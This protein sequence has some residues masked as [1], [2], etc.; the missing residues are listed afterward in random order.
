MASDFS[1]SASSNYASPVSESF[2]RV[3]SPM[4]VREA[5]K[6]AQIEYPNIT[7]QLT[8]GPG[9]VATLLLVFLAGGY[10]FKTLQLGGSETS[11]QETV[12]KNEKASTAVLLSA[13]CFMLII[14]YLGAL[15]PLRGGK[16]YD[17]KQHDAAKS[18]TEASIT[19]AKKMFQL[20]D[21]ISLAGSACLR[22]FADVMVLRDL[23]QNR[24]W[25]AFTVKLFMLGLM[26]TVAAMYTHRQT[27]SAL[28][29]MPPLALRARATS[30][31]PLCVASL[32]FLQ[33]LPATLILLHLLFFVASDDAA[34]LERALSTVHV[35]QIFT[36]LQ[37]TSLVTETI[38]GFFLNIVLL[39]GTNLSPTSWQA[40][41]ISTLNTGRQSVQ[42]W[43]ATENWR[44]LPFAVWGLLSPPEPL[45]HSGQP[46]LACKLLDW[47]VV[48][49]ALSVFAVGVLF[50]LKEPYGRDLEASYPVLQ[51]LLVFLLVQWPLFISLQFAS[52]D[53]FNDDRRVQED[54]A[55]EVKVP[56]HL[57]HLWW[58]I[59]GK[60]EGFSSRGL[61]DNEAELIGRLLAAD[62]A[63]EEL[64]LD[65]TNNEI[66]PNGFG[67]FCEAVSRH[68]NLKKK[69]ELNLDGNP[70]CSDSVNHLPSLAKPTSLVQLKF[71]HLSRT[72]LGSNLRPLAE[73]LVS[74]KT[75]ENLYLNDNGIGPNGANFLAHGL[76]RNKSLKVLTLNKNLEK[77]L[78]N[79]MQDGTSAIFRALAES[80]SSKLRL[81]YIE[82]NIINGSILQEL[83]Q[84]LQ[85]FSFKLKFLNL[86]KNP[87]SLRLL[88]KAL[89]PKHIKK[90]RVSISHPG[91][92]ETAKRLASQVTIL[93]PRTD[94]ETTEHRALRRV[95]IS[96]PGDEVASRVSQP[97]AKETPEE[98][99]SRRVT[100][101]HPGEAIQVAVEGLYPNGTITRVKTRAEENLAPLKYV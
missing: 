59:S 4:E 45:L 57:L 81:L 101:S 87:F 44:K 27:P 93:H 70:L 29:Y 8:W 21:P 17:Y 3:K 91:D 61:G 26:G 19:S 96:H 32:A 12:E 62:E 69:L 5:V 77:L 89:L 50:V 56:M 24:D 31:L 14:L 47:A 98:E 60:T 23:A 63:I 75:L 7:V 84:H 54:D 71:L 11:P 43:R 28:K 85:S 100:L 46:L 78:G 16:G 41:F 64:E 36:A 6:Q 58:D 65:L 94:E 1:P 79:Y 39:S 76:R 53:D 40:L 95:S 48:K 82:R 15:R 67:S 99:V 30:H 88:E 13:V 86:A 92:E 33:L 49:T 80:S 72:A 38:P 22:L 97:G 37:D 74:T 2:S 66:G 90:V 52:Y 34:E 51:L 55:V 25:A 35:P 18:W 9:D 20:I 73:F 42:V 83:L 10:A 68:P